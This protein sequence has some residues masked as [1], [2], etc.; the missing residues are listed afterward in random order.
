MS[1]EYPSRSKE[2]V[3][4]RSPY[5]NYEKKPKLAPACGECRKNKEC[6]SALL[7]NYTSLKKYLLETEGRKEQSEKKVS[8]LKSKRSADR[9]QIESLRDENDFLKKLC[10]HIYEAAGSLVDSLAHNL[11][12]ELFKFPAVSLNIL[13]HYEGIGDAIKQGYLDVDLGLL[14]SAIKKIRT[15]II[16]PKSMCEESANQKERKEWLEMKEELRVCTLKIEKYENVVDILTQSLEESESEITRLEKE[17]EELMDH[18]EE[19]SR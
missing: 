15:T 14:K 8:Q 11:R 18:I 6:Y 7:S 1:A 4:Y 2:L 9:E 12:P 3:K 17:R 10:G 13:E 16:I 19:L 5:Q